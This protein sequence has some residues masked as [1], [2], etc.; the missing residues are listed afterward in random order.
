MEH[1]RYVLSAFGRNLVRDSAMRQRQIAQHIG[2]SESL[3]S[4]ICGGFIVGWT[5]AL[6][7]EKGL[8]SLFGADPWDMT[9]EIMFPDGF[10][11]RREIRPAH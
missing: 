1:T 2:V 10:D 9:I 3:L 6:K 7:L 5:T 8:A 11:R 4:R